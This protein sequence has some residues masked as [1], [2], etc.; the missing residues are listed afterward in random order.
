MYFTENSSMSLSSWIFYLNFLTNPFIF[1]MQYETI[2]LSC[3]LGLPVVDQESKQADCFF[4]I[5]LCRCLRPTRI[6]L[7]CLCCTLTSCCNRKITKDQL[8]WNFLET[9][10][11]KIWFKTFS[12]SAAKRLFQLLWSFVWF[13]TFMNGLKWDGIW[14]F[15]SLLWK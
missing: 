10:L 11:I 7:C 3:E 4:V 2:K 14:A 5:W 1:I 8:A 6:Y 13:S 9:R 12:T 15:H